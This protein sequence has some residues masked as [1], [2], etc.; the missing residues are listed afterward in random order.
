MGQRWTV[1]ALAVTVG[2]L[3]QL[4]RPP[5]SAPPRGSDA[6]IVLDQIASIRRAERSTPPTWID[7]LAPAA[8]EGA[9]RLA[10]GADGRGVANDVSRKVAYGMGRNVEVLCMSTDSLY[11]LNL[12]S[13][14]VGGHN[15]LVA[16][17]VAVM[18]RGGPGRYAIVI[19]TP[20]AG[21]GISP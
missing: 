11:G 16:V 15:L 12:P 17:G 8:R 4:G 3:G 10:D 9:A 20:E 7:R 21:M 6:E 14:L 19:V 13:R 2:C 1:A 5:V 18:R